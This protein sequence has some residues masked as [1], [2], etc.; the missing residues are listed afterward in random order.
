MKRT[1]NKIIFWL[2][3]KIFIGILTG[4]VNKFNH[5]ECVSLSSQK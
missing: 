5:T 1:S 4:I 3:K 2:I